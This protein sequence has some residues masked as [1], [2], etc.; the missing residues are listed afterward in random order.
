MLPRPR[1]RRRRAVRLDEYRQLCAHRCLLVDGG[2]YQADDEAEDSDRRRVLVP[3]DGIDRDGGH[4]VGDAEDGETRRR[5][6]RA[7]LEA[8]ERDRD[9]DDARDGNERD[10]P[11]RP[12]GLAQLGLLIGQ[13]ADGN[14]WGHRD[15]VGV[16]GGAP[17]RREVELR[18]HDVLTERHLE[19]DHDEV[20][21]DPR[22]RRPAVQRKLLVGEHV[23]SGT[24]DHEQHRA[25]RAEGRQP[26]AEERK[27][28]ERDRHRHARARHDERLNV[29]HLKR[30]EV[31]VNGGDEHADVQ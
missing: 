6:E 14:H 16:E 9:P 10:Q 31:A 15:G 5:D 20:E 24:G 12:L 17:H 23:A 11:G 8:E 22:V 3:D 18:P 28:E 25:P 26:P 21:D 1:R 13:Q 27:V 19:R 30:L 4:L 29:G 2:A 7:R